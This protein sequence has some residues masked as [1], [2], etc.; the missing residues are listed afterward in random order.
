MMATKLTQNTGASYLMLDTTT[1]LGI[2]AESGLQ[3][4]R[5][6]AVEGSRPHEI[7]SDGLIIHL[8]WGDVQALKMQ[9]GLRLT[10]SADDRERLFLLQE[11][12]DKRLDQAGIELGRQW[13]LNDLV[14]LPPNVAFTEVDEIARLSPSY[15]RVRLGGA[16]LSR[17]FRDGLHFRLL[18]GPASNRGEW[19]TIG[20]N[21]RTE[22]PGG[23]ESW[24][25]PVY[26]ARAIDAQR[27][28][29]DFDIFAHEGGRVTEWCRALQQG[30]KVAIMGPSGEWYPQAKWLA[31]FG[32]E[33]ALPAIVR[34]LEER[35][36][37]SVGSATILVS[38]EGDVQDLRKPGHVNVNWL[39]RGAGRSLI[40]AVL[41]LDIPQTDRFVWFA[42]E[43]SESEAARRVLLER[44]VGKSEMR[45]ASYWSR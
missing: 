4:M 3:M 28:T 6:R 37:E 27:R 40:D 38:D 32:D 1:V 35:P 9:S 45:T 33:T 22:W 30:D 29:M 25:R 20:S 21:G 31:L 26:T 19:P 36:A 42:G 43:R 7:V 12:V 41:G 23:I 18:F 8:P 2:E 39:L 15:Y 13:S 14:G 11:V 10:L 24:H 34:I 44:G 5:A 17:F 16:D